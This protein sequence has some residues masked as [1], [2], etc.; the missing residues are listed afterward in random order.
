MTFFFFFSFCALLQRRL[1]KGNCEKTLSCAAGSARRSQSCSPATSASPA[2]REVGK[3]WYSQRSPCAYFSFLHSWMRNGGIFTSHLLWSCSAANSRCSG[4]TWDHVIAVHYMEQT[5]DSIPTRHGVSY[6]C[7]KHFLAYLTPGSS[8]MSGFPLSQS[9]PNAT[10]SHCPRSLRGNVGRAALS[11]LSGYDT[12]GLLWVEL[13]HTVHL[14]HITGQAN[15]SS[16]WCSESHGHN[17]YIGLKSQLVRT[18]PQGFLFSPSWLFGSPAPFIQFLYVPS[19]RVTT[20]FKGELIENR[21][22]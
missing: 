8:E 1:K 16:Y 14:K 12:Q 17:H 18:N 20:G 21:S 2:G 3:D 13:N 6:G 19:S 15:I 10:Q 5:G 7:R 11:P 22:Y 4:G 9:D